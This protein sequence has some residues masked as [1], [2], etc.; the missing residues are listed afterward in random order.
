MILTAHPTTLYWLK[1]LRDFHLALMARY[2]Y[3]TRTC[4]RCKDA[5]DS[6]ISVDDQRRWLWTPF[7]PKSVAESK[8]SDQAIFCAIFV[9]IFNAIFVACELTLKIAAV[10]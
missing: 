3:E 2:G 9:A 8:F 7:S 5:V 4:V 10:N 6:V 1:L